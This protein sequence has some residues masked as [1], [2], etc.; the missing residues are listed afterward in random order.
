LNRMALSSVDIAKYGEQGTFIALNDLIE[1]YMPNL[2][3]LL[4][5]NPEIRKVMT[6]PD[7]N[8]Y[9]LPTIYDP[10][11]DSLMMQHKLWVRK[12]WL[13]K[14]GMDVP[15]TIDEFEAYLEAVKSQDPNG[16]GKADEIGAT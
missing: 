13:D 7:G 12:D 15:E 3:A 14:F 5:E 9:S 1:Q 6:F 4:E 8:I 10:D 2:T 11:F 16:N